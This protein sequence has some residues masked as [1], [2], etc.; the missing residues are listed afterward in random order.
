MGISGADCI[1]VMTMSDFTLVEYQLDTIHRQAKRFAARLKLPIT[2]AKDVLARAF[3][4]CAG[5]SD[6]EGRLKGRRADRHLQL[7]A[8]LP[9]S[10]E[11]RSY[12]A[13]ICRDL[14]RS[15]SQHIL[16]NANLAGL[17]D[18]VQDVFA[19][20]SDPTTLNDLVPALDSPAWRPVSIG[21]DPWAVLESEVWINGTCLRLVGTRTYVPRYYDFGPR[22]E[23]G[24]YIE[25]P[26]GKLR[27]IWK[28]PMAWYQAGLDYLE[29]VDADELLLPVVEATEEM[30][31]HQEWFEAALSANGC[32]AE[33]GAGS[34]DLVP[35]IL[36]GQDGPN[37]YVV[38]GYPV[39]GDVGAKQ[40]GLAAV[41]LAATGDNFSKVVL[42]GENPVCLE[43]IEYDS[44]TGKHSGEFC[45]YAETLM[46]GVLRGGCL[47]GTPCDDGRP[48]LLFVRP[49]TEFDIRQEL[50]VD[51][52]NVD[53]EVAFVLKTS[54]FELARELL[55]KVAVRD[56]MAYPFEGSPAYFA[57]LSVPEP[58]ELPELSLTFDSESPGRTMMSNL[59]L[60]T[61][62]KEQEKGAE[63][64]IEIAPKL[65][66]LV[67]RIGKKALAAALNHGLIQRFPVD[68]L[69]DLDQPQARC[70][71]IPPVPAEIAKLLDTRLDGASRFTLRRTHYLRNNF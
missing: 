63:L 54:N 14:A 62:W 40:V 9:Q 41:E 25:P 37:C 48:G 7:L 22:H 71:H 67:D 33:Y 30:G 15:L 3:Y 59:V 6:L 1:E 52:T 31:R 36:D 51:F 58:N 68:F 10:D 12:F 53:D 66:I 47:L 57:L 49:A 69:G 5:W 23:Y 55:E 19:I 44:K 21:P 61:R 43:W 28:E 70:A 32:I 27:I 34:D 16:T 60:S 17:L 65:M 39:V 4:R 18:H 42:L 46:Q 2:A 24:E 64:L 35:T 8:A 11:A 13:D 50:K 45:E 56:L 29:N 26:G 38:F 20:G